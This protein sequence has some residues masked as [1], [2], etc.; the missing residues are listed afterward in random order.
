MVSEPFTM[1]QILETRLSRTSFS[2]GFSSIHKTTKGISRTST[3][4]LII[5]ETFLIT[6]TSLMTDIVS[7]TVLS[8]I[9]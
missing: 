2:S 1:F 4:I 8:K 3:S 7:G 5:G 6:T 9:L